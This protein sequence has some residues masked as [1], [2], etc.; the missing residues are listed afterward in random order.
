[1]NEAHLHLLVNHVPIIGGLFTSIILAWGVLRNNQ[2]IISLG[3]VLFILLGVS[4]FVAHSTGEAAEE[5]VEH[6]GVAFDHQMIHEHEEAAF[7]AHLA[8]MFTALAALLT[9]VVRKL[10]DGRMMPIVVLLLSLVTFGLMARAGNLGGKITHREILSNNM[11][12]LDEVEQHEIDVE[13]D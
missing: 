7:P 4:S 2:S 13:G 6:S 3:L 1:M 10:R 8:M 5:I 12:G 9:L 11:D